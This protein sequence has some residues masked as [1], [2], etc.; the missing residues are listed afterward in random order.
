M[1][2]E[3]HNTH[4]PTSE[5]TPYTHNYSKLHKVFWGMCGVAF[6]LWLFWDVQDSAGIVHS[7]LAQ[8]LVPLMVAGIILV[9][10]LI[11]ELEKVSLLFKKS[12][13]TKA[14][15][16]YGGYALINIFI[17]FLF[18][19]TIAG[20]LLAILIA[21]TIIYFKKSFAL[22]TSQAVTYF[23]AAQ[24]ATHATIEILGTIVSIIHGL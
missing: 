4:K 14:L 21:G 23:V 11:Q 13:V 2:H 10:L 8:L 12:D 1:E 18:P 19:V 24:F 15:Y 20:V 9:V 22:T 3:H 5:R 6:L 17:S 16:I 7:L